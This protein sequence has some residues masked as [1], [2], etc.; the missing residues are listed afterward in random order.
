ML[1][2]MRP[3]NY[4]HVANCYEG[5]AAARG[6]RS[7]LVVLALLA[8]GCAAPAEDDA[9]V[10]AT[11]YPL[12]WAA[13]RLAGDNAT[14]G[15]LVPAGIEP[16]DW[17]PAPTDVARLGRAALVVKQGAGFEPWLDGVLAN[18]GERAPRVVDTTANVTLAEGHDADEPYD[19]HTW[20]D[21][22][23]FAR[24]ARSIQDALA[25]AL[26]DHRA[27]IEE[28]GNLLAADLDALDASYRDGLAQCEARVI[29]ANHD[30]YG[31]LARRYGFEVIAIS[32]LSPEAE[33]SP[34]D[35][36]RAVDAAREHNVT[37]V[38]FEELVSPRVAEVVASEVGAQ[39][40]VLS[41]AESPPEQGDYLTLMRTNLLNLREAMRCT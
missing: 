27:A 23:L 7:I 29:I 40:R 32:G 13:E 21:P 34:Q 10:L 26:P 37:I 12:A 8:A 38:F 31:Y 28:R 9:D 39:T 16:H 14:V 22:V 11:F 41:P 3:P 18:L 25:D 20:L 35:V 24:Q 6:V 1:R 19:P 2:K 17:E 30:A 4:E 15:T 33:P 5:G 36:A